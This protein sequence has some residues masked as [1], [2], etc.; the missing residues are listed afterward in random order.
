MAESVVKIVLINAAMVG[1]GGF[2]GAICRYGMGTYVQRHFGASVFPY[3]TL[4]VNMLGCL[5][6]GLAVG[7][8]ESRQLYSDDFRRFVLIGILGGFTTYSTFSYETLA[9]F[10]NADYLRAISYAGIHVVLGLVLV[11][12]GFGLAA[13]Q[14]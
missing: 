4:A 5:L 12:A 10:H 14:F 9:L 11:W 1:A 8:A 13:K 2:I 7:Y 6:I 3:G